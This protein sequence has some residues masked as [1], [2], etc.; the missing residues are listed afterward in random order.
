MKPSEKFIPMGPC[1]LH[2]AFFIP[3]LSSTQLHLETSKRPGTDVLKLSPTSYI[4][5]KLS[6][7][8]EMKEN[9]KALS[10]KYT[11]NH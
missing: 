4:F 3:L 10:S 1:N 7:Q 8:A 11:S 2:S 5:P 9:I 6:L